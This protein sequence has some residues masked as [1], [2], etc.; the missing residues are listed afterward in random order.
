MLKKLA[1]I[2]VVYLMM[3]TGASINVSALDSNGFTY[4]LDKDEATITNY[5]STEENIDTLKVP[6]Q[7]DGHKV[8]KLDSDFRAKLSNSSDASNVNSLILPDTI[9][10]IISPSGYTSSLFEGVNSIIFENTNDNFYMNNGCLYSKDKANLYFIP[11]GLRSLEIPTKTKNLNL[12]N[13]KNTQLTSFIIPN[14]VERCYV[15]RNYYG[16]DLYLPDSLNVLEI[17]TDSAFK[18]V[19]YYF[20]LQSDYLSKLTYGNNVK[21][22][23]DLEIDCKNLSELNFSDNLVKMPQSI[24]SEKLKE[25]FI[26]KITETISV[27][28]TDNLESFEVDPNNKKF[29]SINGVL[30]SENILEMYPKALNIENYE[31]P[32]GITKVKKIGNKYLKNLKLPSSLEIIMDDAMLNC[33]NLESVNIPEKMSD[34]YEHEYDYHTLFSECTKLKNV[35]VD[36]NS[37]YF[38][39]YDGGLYSKD[40]K[41]LYKYFDG[42]NNTPNINEN[43]KTLC[44]K[45]FDSMQNLEFIDLK[46]V[47]TIEYSVFNECSNLK[48]IDFANI[49]SIGPIAFR[50]CS[51]IKDIKLPESLQSLVTVG[52]ENSWGSTFE[53]CINLESINIPSKIDYLGQD[54]DFVF[55]GCRNLTNIT[56]SNENK[57]YIVEDNALY[58]KEYLSLIKVLD[59]NVTSF[60]TKDETVYVGTEA[61]NSCR[62]IKNINLNNVEEL[63]Y[64][65]LNYCDSV[66]NVNLGKI[67]KLYLGVFKDCNN[68]KHVIVPKSVTDVNGDLDENVDFTLCVYPN[69]EALKSIEQWNSYEWNKHIDYTVINSFA[70]DSSHIKVDLLSQNSGASLQVQQLT[71]GNSYDEIAKYS[72][73]FNLYDISF[74]KDNEKV[75]IDGS[76]IVRIPVKEDMDGNKCKVY[77]NDNGKFTDMN[78]VYKDGHMEFETTHF[79]EYVLVEGSLPTLTMGDVNGDGKVNV[80]DAVMVLRHDANI[81]KLDDSQLKAADVNDDGK[82]DVLDAVMILR[83]EAGI[84][85]NFKG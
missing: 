48:K 2:M 28:N 45:S 58:T 40:Y 78:A 8:T 46:N 27:F 44:T 82:V 12:S 75:N 66:T 33:K 72:D 18:K 22:L 6:S 36:E 53:D 1:V 56:V 71:S 32:E 19:G 9:T 13:L 64:K 7:I 63:H 47:T 23:S 34:P 35:I 29:R 38:T 11:T 74:Y 77:Y 68:L 15:Y 79:S 30:Y 39:T 43:T 3:I 54:N 73:N 51:S 52:V 62:K 84:I 55:R 76:A 17:D 16:A 65:A 37:K 59:K 57:E 41:N 21:D 81:I 42:E 10:E 70:D 60:K 5:E 67:T 49:E 31:V 24:Y 25:I 61:F 50:K 85:K 26:P 14:H 80:L 69:S 20:R 4:T 83:Y